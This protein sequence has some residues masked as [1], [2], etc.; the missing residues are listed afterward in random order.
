MTA[1]L[2]LDRLA[3]MAAADNWL[4]PTSRRRRWCRTLAFLAGAAT[5]AL[6]I[7]TLKLAT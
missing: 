6:A 1:A 5:A 7:L 3:R 2:R 4:H